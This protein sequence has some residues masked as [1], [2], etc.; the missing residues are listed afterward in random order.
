MPKS[1]LGMHKQRV[2]MKISYTSLP[3][4]EG[5]TYAKQCPFCTSGVFGLQRDEE[6]RLKK[7][8]ECSICRQR[9]RWTE[10]VINGEKLV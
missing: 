8:D 5:S 7:S 6:C 2:V 3:F 10:S 4:A 9:V 1:E